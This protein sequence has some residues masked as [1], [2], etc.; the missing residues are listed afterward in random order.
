MIPTNVCLLLLGA[1][2][3]VVGGLSW[4][5]F[6]SENR[7]HRLA[8]EKLEL[9]CRIEKLDRDANGWRA[10]APIRFLIDSYAA[11]LTGEAL[12][13]ASA[14]P[15]L[16]SAVLEIVNHPENNLPAGVV[17]KYLEEQLEGAVG[18]NLRNSPHEVLRA[19]WER[20]FTVP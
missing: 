5:L 10:L 2:A 13:I 6:V 1:V 17:L 4:Q 9:L 20:M 18:E 7:G 16:R 8:L 14:E 11:A 19:S 15:A 3:I 12:R